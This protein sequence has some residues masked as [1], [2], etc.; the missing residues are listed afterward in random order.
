MSWCWRVRKDYFRYNIVF[1]AVLTST[2]K[3][4][5]IIHSVGWSDQELDAYMRIIRGNYVNGLQECL[6]CLQSL[7]RKVSDA[8]TENEKHILSL[9]ARNTEL[10]ADLTELRSCGVTLP[11]KVRVWL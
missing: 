5:K 6:N 10:D 9:R 7:G 2:V 1:S 8:N 4:M 3:Q 11:L